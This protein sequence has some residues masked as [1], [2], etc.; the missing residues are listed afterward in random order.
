MMLTHLAIWIFYCIEEI[1]RSFLVLIGCIPYWLGGHLTRL[2]LIL[3]T[4][5]SVC[6]C[7]S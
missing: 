3:N 7:F 5:R 1:R 4:N 6:I 2:S